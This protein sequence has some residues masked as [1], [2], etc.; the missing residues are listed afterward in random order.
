MSICITI[1]VGTSKKLSLKKMCSSL[2]SNV[3]DNRFV[4]NLLQIMY[5]P[6]VSYPRLSTQY[7]FLAIF[8][9]RVRKKYVPIP[10]TP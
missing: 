3:I 4:A 10:I 7:G 5:V 8:L 9:I 6:P 2:K 1:L